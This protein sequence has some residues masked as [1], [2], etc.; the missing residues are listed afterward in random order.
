MDYMIVTS[1]CWLSLTTEVAKFLKQGWTLQ[2][3]VSVTTDSNDEQYW[4]QAMV[5]KIRHKK[6]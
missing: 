1:D 6:P 4:A 2:G 5:R 3:G